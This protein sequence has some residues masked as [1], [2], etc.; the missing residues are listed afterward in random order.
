MNIVPKIMVNKLQLL[1]HTVLTPYFV[2]WIK[3]ICERRVTEQC[4][5]P[6]SI[7]KY[8]DE[9]LCDLDDMDTCHM[10]LH[11]PQQYDFDETCISRNNTYIFY[12][13]RMKIILAL[14][15]QLL[16]LVHS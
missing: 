10:Y 5:I 3:D 11:Q 16:D 15:R 14:M 6:L 7:R 2:K 8:K 12:S 13:D 4:H 1:T 9:I